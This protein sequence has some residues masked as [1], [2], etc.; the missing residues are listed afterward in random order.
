MNDELV[1]CPNCDAHFPTDPNSWMGLTINVCP[2]C[3]TLLPE[4]GKYIEDYFRIIQLVEPL[5]EAK[6]LFL[7]SKSVAAVREALVTLETIVRQKSGLKDLMGP[8]RTTKELHLCP[9]S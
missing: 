9:M 8:T 5:A 2:Q 7:K 1:K 6:A 4:T 3:G